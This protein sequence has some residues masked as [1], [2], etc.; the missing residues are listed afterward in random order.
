M[1]NWDDVRKGLL[2]RIQLE[3]VAVA[4]VASVV[5]EEMLKVVEVIAQ[6]PGKVFISGSGSSG[7][8]ARRMAHLMSVTGT[9]SIF[10]QPADALHGSLGAV[11]PGDILIVISRGG[12]S[13]EINDLVRRAKVRGAITIA[14]TNTKPSPLTEIVDHIQYFETLPDVDPGDVI[15]MGTNL[16]HATWGD[17]VALTLMRLKNY[18]WDQVLYSHPSGSVGSMQNA[19]ESLEPLTLPSRNDI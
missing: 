15:A 4:S 5:N 19:P 16:M 11:T 17:A 9:P 10:L 2:E 1:A 13:T 3:A 7:T 18:S 14:L 6:T 8:I 12:G